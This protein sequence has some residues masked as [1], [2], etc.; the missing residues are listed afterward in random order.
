MREV[1]YNRHDRCFDVKD[2]VRAIRTNWLI[3]VI[4][5]LVCAA[6][7]IV[8]MQRSEY[9]SAVAAAQ[10]SVGTDV[11][12]IYNGLTDGEKSTIQLAR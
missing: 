11:P 6:F 12:A 7:L 2:M 3:I 4:C 8:G 9:K 5:G 10:E 1:K